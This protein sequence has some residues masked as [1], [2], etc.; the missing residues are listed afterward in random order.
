[1]VLAARLRVWPGEQRL[2]LPGGELWTNPALPAELEQL[3]WDGE[4]IVQL[5]VDPETR[6]IL[7]PPELRR[8]FHGKVREFTRNFISDTWC[9]NLGQ[10]AGMVF[11]NYPQYLATIGNLGIARA[12][13]LRRRMEELLPMVKYNP[14]T[15]LETMLRDRELWEELKGISRGPAKRFVTFL[16]TQGLLNVE[17]LL[18]RYGYPHADRNGLPGWPPQEHLH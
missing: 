6:N 15:V 3:G 16:K 17:G 11:L 14:A 2:V 13:L 7:A 18:K 9:A 5:V 12:L 10:P 4:A 1:M 8:A